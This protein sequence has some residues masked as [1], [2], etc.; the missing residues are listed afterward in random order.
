MRKTMGLTMSNELLY[1]LRIP[2]GD[3][4]VTRKVPMTDETCTQLRALQKDAE[5]LYAD[6]IGIDPKY[7]RVEL[8]TLLQQI[9]RNAYNGLP[10]EQ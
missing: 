1:K 4:V 2:E 9:I 5:E 3:I 7:V 10:K 8:P 6:G